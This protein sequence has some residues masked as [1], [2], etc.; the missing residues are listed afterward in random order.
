M[1]QVGRIG[2]TILNFENP[3]SDL[4]SATPK[5]FTLEILRYSEVF[6]LRNFFVTMCSFSS[7]SEG[8]NVVEISFRN[9]EK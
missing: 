1:F 9:F 3:T 8:V 4:E 2:S 7:D 6:F 5:T